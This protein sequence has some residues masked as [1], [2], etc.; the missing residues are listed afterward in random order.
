M[1]S[2]DESTNRWGW[3]RLQEIE[4]AL[5]H[6]EFEL[7]SDKLNEQAVN[8]LKAAQQNVQRARAA[9]KI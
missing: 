4:D 6:A 1:P 7:S 9:L 3:A 5:R 2:R 8:L